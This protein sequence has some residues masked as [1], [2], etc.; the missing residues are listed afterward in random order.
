MSVHSCPVTGAAAL[1]KSSQI[2]FCGPD[3]LELGLLL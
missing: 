1:Y 2:Q 3:R